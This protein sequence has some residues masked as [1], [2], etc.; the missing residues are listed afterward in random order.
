MTP[1]SLRVRI[2]GIAAAAVSRSASGTT[3]AYDAGYLNHSD[4]VPLSLSLPLRTQAHIGPLIETW[5]DGLLPDRAAEREQWRALVG[6][7]SVDPFDLLGSPIGSECAGAVQFER[8]DQADRSGRRSGLQPITDAELS[9]ALRDLRD[10]ARPGGWRTDPLAS[11]S[12][13]G[14]MPKLALRR[15][16][17]RWHAAHGDETTSHLLKPSLPLYPGQAVGEHLALATARRLGI[18]A[19]HTDVDVIDGVETLIV[20]RFDRI[21]TAAHAA[22][23]PAGLEQPPTDLK[24]VHQEDT[25]QA[26]GFGAAQRFQRDGGPAPDDI[27]RLLRQHSSSPDADVAALFTRLAYCWVIVAN[28][29]HAKNHAILHLPGGVCRLAPLYDTASWLPYTDVPAPDIHLAMTLGNGFHVG[30]GTRLDDW[31]STARSFSL[32]PA[33]AAD[34]VMRL[35]RETPAHLLAEVDNLPPPA[36]ASGAATRLLQ[37]ITHRCH[38]LT[39]THSGE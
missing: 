12:L 16:Q 25:C 33:W 24:R 10:G 31:R 19:A 29:A 30:Q 17:G 37:T 2:N 3:L 11:F 26:L 38:T 15:H 7:A 36:R 5:L 22:S 4:A 18:D 14:T 39:A 6:A 1:A 32:D 21:A 34:E 35:V 20:Q 23:R 8:A 9:A 27:A 28:D 13:A